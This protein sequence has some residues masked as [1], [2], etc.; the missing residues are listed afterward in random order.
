MNP[1]D[2]VASFINGNFEQMAE[3]IKEY[4]EIQF[5]TDLK[6]CINHY[7]LKPEVFMKM[8]IMYFKK[9]A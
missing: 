2:I 5:F 4:G 1:M 9:V 8:T 7:D 6:D 3:Q